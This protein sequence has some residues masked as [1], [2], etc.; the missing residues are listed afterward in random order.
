MHKLKLTKGMSYNGVVQATR[1]QPEVLIYEENAYQSAMASGYFEEVAISQEDGQQ[2][3]TDIIHQSLGEADNEGYENEEQEKAGHEGYER[4]GQEESAVQ[5]N[6]SEHGGTP[7]EG[8]D[9][10]ELKAYAA[11]NGIELSGRKKKADIIAAIKAGEEK[12]AE[13]RSALRLE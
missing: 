8:M 7:I 1:E 10:E 6:M 3:E 9:V 12:A 2:E 11:L 13:A 4:T 5:K